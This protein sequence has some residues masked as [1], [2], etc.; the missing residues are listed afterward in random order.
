MLIIV[1]SNDEPW[2]TFNYFTARSD[3]VILLITGLQARRAFTG[4]LFRW[5]EIQQISSIGDAIS[6][7]RIS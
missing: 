7:A 6:I 3:M 1:C 4:P 2:F 5:F